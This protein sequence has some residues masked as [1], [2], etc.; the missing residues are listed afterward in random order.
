VGAGKVRA[1][2]RT[3]AAAKTLYPAPGQT[4]LLWNN[5]IRRVVVA[6]SGFSVS[7]RFVPAGKDCSYPGSMCNDGYDFNTGGN[8]PEYLIPIPGFTNYELWVAP[9]DQNCGGGTA[10]GPW[11]ISGFS[12]ASALPTPTPVPATPYPTQPPMAPACLSLA[13][14]ISQP[15][16]GDDVIFVCGVVNGATRYEFRYKMGTGAINSLSSATGQA[17]ISMPL[18][19]TEPLEY[20]VQ[21]RACNVTGCG[22]FEPM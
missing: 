21:C 1:Q 14:N 15:A 3:G 16:L 8:V 7:Y 18:K 5:K 13:R 22:D 9:Y 20:K 6:T 4:V 17:N 10:R 19:I 11:S 2:C 12:I